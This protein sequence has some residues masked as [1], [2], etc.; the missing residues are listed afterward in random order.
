[1]LRDPIELRSAGEI[2]GIDRACQVVHAILGE[3]ARLA[4]PGVS[5]ADLDRVAE[6]R[7]AERGA[8]PAFK[9]Y[10][11]FPACLCASVN[12]QVVHGIPSPDRILRQGDIVSLDFGAVLDGWYGDAAITVPVGEADPAAL[13]LIEVTREALRRAAAAARPGA[14]I[15]DLGAAVQSWVEGQ[16][17]AVVR[18]FVGH[19][20]GR[21]LHEAPQIPNFGIAGTGIGLRPG[22][23]LAI[24]PMVNTGTPEVD[25]LDDGW[26]AVTLDGGLS[27]HFEHTVAVTEA[28]PVILGLSEAWNPPG[29]AA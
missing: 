16:G 15:G 25:V 27:A 24:E 18:D 22:M 2:A 11:G 13:R 5:T 20:I 4:A 19:G 28:G 8:R 17:F 29:N 1:V 9:G 12:D 21:S 14:R 6:A 23:V 26:T 10:H 3:L 7:L